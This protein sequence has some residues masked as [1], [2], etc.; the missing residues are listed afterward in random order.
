[1]KKTAFKVLAFSAIC[2]VMFTACDSDDKPTP[3]EET[4]KSKYV[5]MTQHTNDQRQGWITA[6]DELPKG[7]ISN[8]V[9]NKSLGGTGM[10][11]WRPYKNWLMKMFNSTG[12]EMGVEQINISETNVVTPGRFIKTSNT[13]NG[14]GNF[15]IVDDTKGYYWDG[16]S[17]LKIQTFNP[18]TMQRTGEI[19]LTDAVN[20]RGKDEAGI[21]YR[22][23]GQK[24]LAVKNGKL[25]ANLTYAKGANQVQWGF[26]DDF[27]ADVYIAVIDVATGKYEKTIKAEDTGS[28]SYINDNNMYSF[29]TNGDLYIVTQGRTNVGGKSKIIRIKANETDIDKT[30]E[31]RMDDLMEGGKF[32]TIYATNGKLITTKPTEKLAST[33]INQTPIW[34]FNVIDVATKQLTKI[35]GVP[36]V[37]NP[38]AGFA[39]VKIDDKLLLRV[40]APGVNGYYELNATLTSATSL[41]N[42]TEGGSISGFHKIEL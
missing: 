21:L 38:G 25:Y 36:L 37:T 31:I 35:A 39:T 17:P 13:R 12:Y 19:D 8:I 10:A 29:D 4:K 5:L 7:D 11:G 30:W 9:A 1:M 24:V 26:F 6:F 41:F 42:V 23:A 18:T 20:E 33:N 16:D 40:N 15:T 34:E 32:V 27:Y 3:P 14:S 28:I 22:S 2:A